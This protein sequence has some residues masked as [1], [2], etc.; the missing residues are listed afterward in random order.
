MPPTMPLYHGQYG[1]LGLT[2]LALVLQPY[3]STRIMIVIRN[4]ERCE[5]SNNDQLGNMDVVSS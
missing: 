3:E 4:D 2:V 1:Q 5:E